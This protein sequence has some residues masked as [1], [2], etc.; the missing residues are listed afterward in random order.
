MCY[1]NSI[2][3]LDSKEHPKNKP[4]ASEKKIDARREMK[5]I[6]LLYLLVRTEKYSIQNFDH[7]GF[8]H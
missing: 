6:S 5:E 3:R 1:C 4:E 2:Y 7:Q 8:V